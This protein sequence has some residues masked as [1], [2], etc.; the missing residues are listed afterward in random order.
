MMEII[1][2]NEKKAVGIDILA[3]ESNRYDCVLLL[4]TM[5]YKIQYRKIAVAIINFNRNT[6][7]CLMY[8]KHAFYRLYRVSGKLSAWWNFLKIIPML[9]MSEIVREVSE[10]YQLHAYP[11]P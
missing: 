5:F 6:Y 7:C 9:N 2:S 8:R 10:F 3:M 1:K 4:S 11:N